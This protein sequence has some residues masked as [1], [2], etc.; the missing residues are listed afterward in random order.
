MKKAARAKFGDKVKVESLC[1]LDTV[2]KGK[3]V[4]VIGTLYKHQGLKPNILKDLSEDNGILPQPPPAKYISEEDELILE[5]E[6]QR[7]K[8]RG[9]I[10]KNKLTTGIVC[11]LYGQEK[12]SGKFHVEAII[13]PEAPKQPARP[14]YDDD[15]YVRTYE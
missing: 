2:E 9:N 3:D 7:I 15:R 14:K 5:D 8:C 4:V 6:N 1:H 11:G 10:D 12:E 13:Y